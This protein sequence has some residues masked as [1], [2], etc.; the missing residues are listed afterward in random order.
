MSQT[1]VILL[2][3]IALAAVAGG[4]TYMVRQRERARIVDY[5]NLMT[6]THGRAMAHYK[7]ARETAD[8]INAGMAS[9]QLEVED[10]E[11]AMSVFRQ[12]AEK[13]REERESLDRV[14]PPAEAE[15]LH[16][17]GLRFLEV[18]AELADCSAEIMELMLKQAR[19]IEVSDSEARAVTRA[20]AAKKKE[21]DDLA[22]VIRNK[23]DQLIMN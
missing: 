11:K 23:K 1:R 9:G 5:A 20:S 6:E 12:A 7:E 4:L 3:L 19:G 17:D 13:T 22:N 2:A 21:V 10:V 8:R 18:R 14:I 15:D 16:Q